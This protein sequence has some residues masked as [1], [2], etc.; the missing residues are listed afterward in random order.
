MDKLFLCHTWIRLYHSLHIYLCPGLYESYEFWVFVATQSLFKWTILHYNYMFLLCG[1]WIFRFF[2]TNMFSFISVFN[3]LDAQ[4]LFHNKFCASSWLN[5]EM[6][7][8]QNVKKC[9][10]LLNLIETLIH[11]NNLIFGS[12]ILLTFLGFLTHVSQV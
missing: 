9:C 3:Q 6:H 2:H 1:E 10:H 8:Q 4:N 11:L 12:W 7:G 5:T